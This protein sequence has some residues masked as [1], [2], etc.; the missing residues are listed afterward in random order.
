MRKSPIKEKI[1]SKVRSGT[2][3]ITTIQ[4]KFPISII[5]EH[6]KEILDDYYYDKCISITYYEYFTNCPPTIVFTWDEEYAHFTIT[7]SVRIED[8]M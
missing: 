5:P 8:W 1:A 6:I 2:D 3:G 4:H 7:I